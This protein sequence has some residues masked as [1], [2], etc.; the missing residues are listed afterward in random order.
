MN[1]LLIEQLTSKQLPKGYT[2]IYSLVKDWAIPKG[3]FYVAKNKGKLTKYF[4]QKGQLIIFDG[5]DE[6]GIILKPPTSNGD[7]LVQLPSG[8]TIRQNIVSPG[9]AGFVSL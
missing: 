4:P 8:K 2:R 5:F 9:I 6:Y 3:K 1:T 7:Y